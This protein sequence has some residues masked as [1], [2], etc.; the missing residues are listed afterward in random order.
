VSATAAPNGCGCKPNSDSLCTYDSNEGSNA[1]RC[2]VCDAEDIL[3][4]ILASRAGRLGGVCDNC[5][6][7]LK[8]CPGSEP[9]GLT[10][11]AVSACF[12]MVESI[13]DVEDCF[14]VDT[15]GGPTSDGAMRQACLQG[16]SEECIKRP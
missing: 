15:S 13:E 1:T 6:S 5:F 9:P 2:F 14:A 7:C 8:T 10:T 4:E 16:C 11:L 3:A 12:M